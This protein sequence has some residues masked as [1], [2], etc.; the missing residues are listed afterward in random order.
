MQAP[1]TKHFKAGLLTAVVALTGCSD[2]IGAPHPTSAPTH[3]IEHIV[4]LVQE[5]RSFDNLFAGFPGAD[6]AMHGWCKPSPGWCKTAREVPLHSVRLATGS[7]SFGKDI[8][9]SHRGFEIECDRNS[10]NV[11]RMD[12]FDLIR[13]GESADGPPAKLYPYAYVE[14]SETAPYWNL[15]QR[16]TLADRMFSTDT[17]SSFIAH[18]ELIAGTVRLNDRESLTDQPDNTPWGCDAPP[19]TV[20]PVLFRNGRYDAHGPFPCF[21]EYETIA[22]LLDARNVSYRYYV[23]GFKE[24]KPH[25]DFS[26]AVWNGFDAI[27]GFRYSPD[28]KTH[29]SIPNTNIFADA[30]AATLPAVSWVV[31]NLH[32]SDHAASGCNG[33]P[34]WVT[35][36]VNALGTSRYW[37]SVAIVL[38]WDDWGGWYDN[39]PPPQVNYTSLGARVPM[40]VISPYAKPHFISHTQYDFGSILKLI[41]QNFGLG[42]LGTTDASANSMADVFDFTQPPKAFEPAA[43]PPVESCGKEGRAGG[44]SLRQ[45]IRHDG[46]VPE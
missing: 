26:G 20:T 42:S 4:I 35:K 33:G 11:C 12:G 10:A 31:P 37:K 32:D 19:G 36:V 18:Q 21:T 14:R 27:K 23:D 8:E 28:W 40:I 7:P 22:A 41:E 16:Y 25:F 5:N 45:I 46:G 38:L 24:N 1:A 2:S 3:P 34:W 17:A 30:E 9:H 39:V 43:L 15:A 13:F 29:I 44:A 6:T